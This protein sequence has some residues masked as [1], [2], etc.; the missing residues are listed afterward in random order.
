MQ[1]VQTDVPG[2][3]EFATCHRREACPRGEAVEQLA[4]IGHSVFSC[5]FALLLGEARSEAQKN[6]KAGKAI[7]SALVVRKWIF[8]SR[9]NR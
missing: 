9:G 6:T 3:F 4:G 5:H 8:S 7:V 1:F 2:G